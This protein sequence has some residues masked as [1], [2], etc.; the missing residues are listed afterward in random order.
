MTSPMSVTALGPSEIEGAGNYVHVLRRRGDASHKDVFALFFMDSG[1]YYRSEKT[2]GYDYF[3]PSQV[4]WFQKASGALEEQNGFNVP[5]M[6]FF[7]IP[8]FEF[9][10][11]VDRLGQQLEVL[12]TGTATQ[13]NLHGTTRFITGVHNGGMFGAFA[14]TGNVFAC[15]AGHDHINDYCGRA[16]GIHMCFA[17]G[18]TYVNYGDKKFARRVRVFTL[19]HKGRLLDALDDP[20]APGLRA[21]DYQ[22]L[23]H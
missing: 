23:R 9:N 13:K 12:N 22:V 15:A 5:A 14:R 8:L 1:G 4:A 10:D 7:H 6:A 11:A 19:H 21:L 20:L 17:G 3:D 18:T 16:H 2:L